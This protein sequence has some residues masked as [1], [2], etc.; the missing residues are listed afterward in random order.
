[1]KKKNLK[2][3]CKDLWNTATDEQKNEYKTKIDQAFDL[4]FNEVQITKL[5]SKS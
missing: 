4:L 1:M 5:K 2:V 3:V